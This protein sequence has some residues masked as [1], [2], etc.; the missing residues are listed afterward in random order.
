MKPQRK[1]KPALQQYYQIYDFLAAGQGRTMREI[2]AE[3]GVSSSLV[4]R[5]VN[6]MIYTGAVVTGN[7][8]GPMVYYPGNMAGIARLEQLRAKYSTDWIDYQASS[9]RPGAGA[10]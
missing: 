10:Q 7:K 8:N 5:M 2:T 4:R 9:S 6:R 1:Y 3:L